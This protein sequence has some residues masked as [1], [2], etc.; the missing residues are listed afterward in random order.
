M[1]FKKLNTYT[2]PNDNSTAQVKVGEFIVTK[3]NNAT[4]MRFKVRATLRNTG[5]ARA[6]TAAERA[7]FLDSFD[8]TLSWGAGLQHK[9]RSNVG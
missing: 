6:L 7:A 4:A 2:L 5:T 1:T 9:P 3:G 8:Y